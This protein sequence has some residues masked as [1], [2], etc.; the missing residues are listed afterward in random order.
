MDN[1]H[2]YMLVRQL[3][4][5][6]PSFDAPTACYTHKRPLGCLH[7]R[8]SISNLRSLC[9]VIAVSVLPSTVSANMVQDRKLGGDWLH[10][11]LHNPHR[12]GADIRMYPDQN[13][14]GPRSYGGAL[15][16]SASRIH[17]DCCHEH[18]QRCRSL[19]PS[20][21]HGHQ[22]SYSR[23]AEDWSGVYFW[24]RIA[25]N[26]HLNRSTLDSQGDADGSRRD[27]GGWKREY[28]DVS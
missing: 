22:P 6:T 25:Y 24:Y 26:H 28:L 4:K 20:S 14:L 5:I 3:P 19:C 15:Y 1:F 10:R 11:K 7:C 8:H 13:E 17:D 16:Q 2:R 23:A 21:S 18:R 12:L 9:K 27:L